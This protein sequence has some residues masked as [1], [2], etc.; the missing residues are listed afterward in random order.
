[1]CVAWAWIP[2]LQVDKTCCYAPRKSLL[3]VLLVG[4]VV[5]R[6][7]AAGARETVRELEAALATTRGTVQ[8]LQAALESRE[9][10]IAGL[11]Q[12]LTSTKKERD[13]LRVQNAELINKLAIVGRK[14]STSS[15]PKNIPR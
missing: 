12:M 9:A 13:E 7:D 4:G 11:R 2:S 6:M 10:D 14:Q 15:P 8:Q 5:A 1:M 3:F